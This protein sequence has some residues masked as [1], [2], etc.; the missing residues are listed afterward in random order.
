MSR[1][2]DREAKPPLR[3]CPSCKTAKR[4]AF[5]YGVCVTCERSFPK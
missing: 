4:E 5:S 1:T 2:K 3:Y